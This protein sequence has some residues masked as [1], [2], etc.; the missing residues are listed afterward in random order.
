MR[1]LRRFWVEIHQV[2][3]SVVINQFKK[4]K[5]PAGKQEADTKKLLISQRDRLAMKCPGQDTRYWKPGAVFEACCPKCEGTVEFFKD[6]TTRK[7][8]QCGHRVVNPKM[9]FGCAAY[10]PYAEQCLGELPPE[11]ASKNEKLLRNRVAVEMKRY[12]GSD[13]KRIGHAANVARYVEQISKDE[14][15]DMATTLCA[16]YL[17]DIGIHEAERKYNSTDAE[18]QHKEGPPI[19][20][21]ILTRLG[22]S[23]LLVEEVCDIV[24]HHHQPRTSES[25][26]YKVVYDADLIVNFE[27][28][29]KGG[30]APKKLQESIYSSFLTDTGRRLAR[31][32]FSAMEVNDENN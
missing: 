6:D 25:L 28:H 26:N 23:P 13:F 32:L 31:S 22:A 3:K 9:D 27:E 11:I 16:A 18:Y 20:R 19:A 29:L 1:I 21:E 7:C 8:S 4:I 10:C 5:P 2:S 15:A 14:K 30:I 17:H 24:A 12:F